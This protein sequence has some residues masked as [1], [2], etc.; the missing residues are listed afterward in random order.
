MQLESGLFESIVL[1]RDD[2]DVSA[3]A[4]SGVC[5]VA[6]DVVV[7]VTRGGKAL[8]GHGEAKVGRASR[9]R[10]KGELAG[11]PVGGPYR[12]ELRIADKAGRT[13]AKAVV[14]DVLV[15]DVWVLGGQSNMQGCGR[16]EDRHKPHRMVRAFYMDDRWAAAED[17]IHNMWDC[18]DECH[19]ELGGGRQERP[20]PPQSGV[21]P[22]VA[23]G[24][25]M[26]E[27]TSVPQGLLACAHG[28]TSMS[29]WDPTLHRD[30]SSS[31]YGATIRRV[32]KN[33]G[34]IAGV[35]WYQGESD[36]DPDS[37][38]LY[39]DRMKTL[40]R[41]LRRDVGDRALPWAVVQI[42]RVVGGWPA[43]PWNSVQDQQRQLQQ[44][45]RR[46]AVAP[47]VDLALDDLIHIAGD[48]QQVLGRRLA[49]AMISLR[50]VKGKRRTVS[51]APPPAFKRVRIT[52][53]PVTG[54]GKVAIEYDH[55]VGR[56]AA[57]SRPAGF[58]LV[59]DGL[60]TSIYRT[61]LA[62]SRVILHTTVGPGGLG[63]VQLHYGHGTDPYCNIVD[64][65]GRALPVMGPVRLTPVAALSPYV[66]S[67]LISDWQ[68][69]M[70]DLTG[71][72]HPA[73]VAALNLKR[74]EFPQRMLDVH[75]QL[76]A[77]TNGD[78]LAYFACTLD[79]PEP[80][81]LA[82]RLGYDGPVKLWVDGEELFHDPKG[83]NPAFEDKANPRFDVSPGRH[84]VLVA[85][86]MNGG[87][88][89]GIFLRFE[90]LDVTKAQL[91]KGADA[92]AMPRVD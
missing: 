76:A 26:H 56:L 43:E 2:G 48:D 18:V 57:A 16:Y 15:G 28:G 21:G 41:S 13:L 37:A 86:G 29:Q 25:A 36:C 5:E 68:D 7:R 83:T 74:C 42:G 32:K 70:G 87:A 89:W 4:F 14:K 65:A 55:V 49:Q 82:A 33:G 27:H 20:N 63:D 12:V 71:L 64:Q 84:H 17:P 79:C 60:E 73:N 66:R 22:G 85:L 54:L 11:I 51:T 80:M 23:F 30:G 61:E 90:R 81:T 67:I 47:A 69:G 59:G 34:K 31:L 44:K 92:Y 50:G 58:D 46:V 35:V 1:Q 77:E 40:I 38:P 19:V 91:A 9:G 3:A 10:F 6:G 78:A 88:A 45:V 39:T 52:A 24:V 8:R 75:E 62:G 53:D 72:A